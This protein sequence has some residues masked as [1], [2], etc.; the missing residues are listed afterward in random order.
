MASTPS[1]AAR[2]AGLNL[3]G[4]GSLT[5]TRHTASPA[6]AVEK[7]RSR[8]SRSQVVVVDAV[9]FGLFPYLRLGLIAASREQRRLKWSLLPAIVNHCCTKGVEQR[10]SSHISIMN[11]SSYVHG[12][13]NI[14]FVSRDLTPFQGCYDASK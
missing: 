12:K 2:A 4:V 9:F 10:C 6:L 7:S 1:F 3:V 11:T 8:C 14:V 13:E 5:V